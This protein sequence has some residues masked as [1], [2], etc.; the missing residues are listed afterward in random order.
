MSLFDVSTKWHQWTIPCNSAV[1]DRWRQVLFTPALY[2]PVTHTV[3]E[4]VTVSDSVNL[5]V[6]FWRS[7]SEN[8]F[9]I[10]CIAGFHLKINLPMMI[11][12][13]GD[14]VRRRLKR[15]FKFVIADRAFSWIQIFCYR[16][17]NRNCSLHRCSWA[18]CRRL[19]C[20]SCPSLI[21]FNAQLVSSCLF[22]AM[23]VTFSIFLTL[24][25]IIVRIGRT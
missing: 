2:Q 4:S 17:Y 10:C 7:D 11:F 25:L 9:S 3:T 8:A 20:S 12:V 6:R 24:L 1:I 22:S 23:N 16:I 5:T 14:N 18:W 13:M 19:L 15:N 21:A